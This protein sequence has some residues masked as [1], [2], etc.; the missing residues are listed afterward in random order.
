MSVNGA[1]WTYRCRECS[2]EGVLGAERLDLEEHIRRERGMGEFGPIK[3]KFGCP[4]CH[5]PVVR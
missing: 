4:E 3:K 5:F 1:E 2:W